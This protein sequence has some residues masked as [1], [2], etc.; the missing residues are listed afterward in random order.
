MN[1]TAVA[2][3]RGML[4][5]SLEEGLRLGRV[6][7]IFF[8]RES[9]QV[10][11]ISYKG[12]RISLDVEAFVYFDEIE[13]IGT[14]VIIVSSSK[15]AREL[16]EETKIS[17][18]RSMK[19]LLVTTDDGTHIGKVMD[20]D[21]NQDDWKVSELILN[22]GRSVKVEIDEIALG[23]NAI[24]LPT[25][26]VA[27]IEDI[28]PDKLSI[29]QRLTDTATLSETAKAIGKSTSESLKKVTGGLGQAITSTSDKVSSA[30]KG[31]FDKT[32][33]AL[34]DTTDKLGGSVRSTI[35]KGTPKLGSLKDSF[36]PSQNEIN[37]D[38]EIHQKSEGSLSNS[39][40][41]LKVDSDESGSAATEYS[42][43]AGD[44][45]LLDEAKA[46]KDDLEYMMKCCEAELK[47][48]EETGSLPDPF[49][50]E[51]VAIL[52]RKNKDYQQEVDYCEK[53]I[54]A[55]ESYSNN[56]NKKVS[57]E[58]IQSKLSDILKR[59]PRAKELLANQNT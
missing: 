29:T 36:S 15:S 8:D 26:C 6:I 19:G 31:T 14:D 22:K 16:P 33:I 10:A 9:K 58:E 24:V 28:S 27:R 30:F 45:E 48:A 4:V 38:S 55:V 34:K 1:I 47:A 20:L 2:D 12:A 52:S 57:E 41:N 18:L 39:E 44:T 35:S 25:G 51:R 3:L 32:A 40:S 11:G 54:G 59:L 43:N 21:V 46:K 50:F 17:G 23:V 5:V 7:D 53:Y 37:D 42:N 49:C 13:K 56:G